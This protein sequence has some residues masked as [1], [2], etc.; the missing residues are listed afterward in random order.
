MVSLWRTGLQ[1]IDAE[2][3]LNVWD[4]VSV[5]VR[6]SKSCI[7]F[8]QAKMLNAEMVQIAQ[9][10]RVMIRSKIRLGKR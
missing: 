9:V 3:F 2:D 10:V 5:D 8:K 1:K 4:E 7:L 6:V